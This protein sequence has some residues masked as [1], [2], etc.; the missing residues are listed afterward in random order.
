MHRIRAES[1]G[2]T[3]DILI[4]KIRPIVGGTAKMNKIVNIK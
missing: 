1:R 2:N 4:S 3:A